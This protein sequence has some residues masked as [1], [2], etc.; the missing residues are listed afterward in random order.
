MIS[1][2]T[3]MCICDGGSTKPWAAARSLLMEAT[4]FEN[5]LRAFMPRGAACTVTNG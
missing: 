2:R 4:S 3:S 5:L 1:T